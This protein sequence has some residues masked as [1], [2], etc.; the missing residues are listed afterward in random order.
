MLRGMGRVLCG[1]LDRRVRQRQQPTVLATD[2]FGGG[3]ERWREHGREDSPSCAG[4]TLPVQV[5]VALGT[6]LFCQMQEA[7]R[8]AVGTW[9]A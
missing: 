5:G 9:E 7:V 1:V 3:L 6:I 2:L 4:C 8:C